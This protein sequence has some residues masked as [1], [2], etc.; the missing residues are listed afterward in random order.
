MLQ[1][2]ETRPVFTPLRRRSRTASTIDGSGS[3]PENML[4]I[5][6]RVGQAEAL[7]EGGLEVVLAHLTG[8]QLAEVGERL[9]IVVLKSS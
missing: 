6:R 4:S 3:I 8:L 2:F 1:E 9:R 7:P 5:S